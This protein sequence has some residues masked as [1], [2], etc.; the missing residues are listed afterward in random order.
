MVRFYC[1]VQSLYKL[2]LIFSLFELIAQNQVKSARLYNFHMPTVI[3]TFV[4]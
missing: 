3:Q 4:I 1:L 2:Y